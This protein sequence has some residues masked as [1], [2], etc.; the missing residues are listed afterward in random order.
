MDRE[1][2]VRHVSFYP[3]FDLLFTDIIPLTHAWDRYL[4]GIDSRP[5]TLF[6]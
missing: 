2:F 4:A 6:V 1:K 3:R 5:E